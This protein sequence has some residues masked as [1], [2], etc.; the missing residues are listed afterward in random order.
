MTPTAKT[1]LHKYGLLYISISTLSNERPALNLKSLEEYEESLGEIAEDE[2]AILVRVSESG[3]HKLRHADEVG[4][5]FARPDG[6]MLKNISV[7]EIPE[8]EF[9]FFG[10]FRKGILELQ[11]ELPAFIFGLGQVYAYSLFESFIMDVLR[12]RIG[13]HPECMGAKKQVNYEEV[14]GTPSKEALVDTLISKEITE[15]LYLPISG[16]LGYLRSRL[17]FRKLAT[18]RDAIIRKISLERNCLIHNDGKASA[19]LAGEF[20]ESYKHSQ[21]IEFTQSSFNL[22]IDTLRRV[23]VAIDHEWEE[24]A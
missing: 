16:V 7:L 24:M 8:D 5:S 21:N 20:P 22:V 18:D 9:Y 4:I 14:F 13:K 17:G 6:A 23:S 19:L 2:P 11:N 10:A 1:L 15:I 3:E 12:D